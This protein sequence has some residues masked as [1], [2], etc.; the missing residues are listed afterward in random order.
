ML[1]HGAPIERIPHMRKELPY[2]KRISKRQIAIWRKEG[3]P[4]DGQPQFKT[5]LSGTKKHDFFIF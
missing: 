4:S 2:G 1:Y 5:R 3:T